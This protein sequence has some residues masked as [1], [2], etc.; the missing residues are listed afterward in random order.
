MESDILFVKREFIEKYGNH[1]KKM[2]IYF[3]PGR[4]NLI[5]EHTDYNGGFVFPCALNFGT[6]LVVRLNRTEQIR[7]ATTNFR[8]EGSVSTNR[9]E[10][11]GKHW[12]NYPM[13]VMDQFI[14]RGFTLSGMDM[15]FSGTVPNSAGL[16]SSAS[17][18]MVTAFALNELLGFN[19]ELM[20]LIKLSQKAEN[21]FV[22]VNCGIM[23]QFAS[24]MGKKDHAIFINC[25]TLD[26]QT[27]PL[28]PGDYKI[29]IS[30][31]NKRRGL[32]SSKYNERRSQCE[33]AVKM[34]SQAGKISFLGELSLQRFQEIQHL[35]N[36]GIILKRA[37]H[38]I[39]ENQRVLDAIAA[40]QSDDL[41]RFGQLMNE[42]HNSLRDDYEVTGIELDTLVEEARKVD[43]VLGSR[44]TGAGFGGCTVSL[45]HNNS[46]NHFTSSVGMAYKNKIGLKPDF[47]IAEI[48]DGARRLE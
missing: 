14:K 17:I 22:G 40:L 29:I 45:V 37:R 39:S 12:I 43:G 38:V 20:D 46:L 21:E 7:L 5:G 32:A 25:H 18:E 1:T 28:N 31:T 35:I 6:Y 9:M 36:D 15:M 11:Q 23:D 19:L 13:G 2:Q 8:F 33:S 44:M 27:I 26:Y 48:G 30:N 4:V 24:A 16:S 34:L 10:P 41:T 3:A 47:Y 42:S